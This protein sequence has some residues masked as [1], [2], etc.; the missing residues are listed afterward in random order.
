MPRKRKRDQDGIFARPDSPFW[1]ASYTNGGGQPTRR[2]TGIRCETDP[3]GIKARAIRA[4]WI[5][6]VDT[7]TSNTSLPGKTF[8][9]LMLLYLKGPS[10]EK[11]SERDRYSA[12]RLYPVFTG[13]VLED[14]RGADV[15]AYIEQRR[16]ECVTAGTIN[17]EIGLLSAAINW[18]RRELEWNIP[19]PCLGRR[20]VEPAGRSRWLTRAEATALLQSA[21]GM[22]RAPHL[23]DFIRLGLNTGMRSGEML[24]LEWR[25]VDLQ[26]G[27]IYLEAENQKNGKVGS[28]PLNQEAREGLMARARFRSQHCPDS[29]WVFCNR[30]GERI[31]CVKTAFYRAVSLAG[32]EDIHPHDLRRT[33]GSWLV[34]AGV[35]IHSVSALLRH[36]DIRVTDRVCA[37][38]SPSEIRAAVDTLTIQTGYGVSRYRKGAESHS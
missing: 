20:L 2:S 27:L 16:A 4:Q 22:N 14:I 11:R 33:C 32:L 15:R 36:S 29:P 37:H 28:V 18:A 38:L 34:Q 12:K 8:D 35:P 25:R 23:V 13:K 1:W 7:P 30:A 5:L 17:K 9:Q 31:A 21:E 24:E 10:A 26:A 6:E 3:E 19:N